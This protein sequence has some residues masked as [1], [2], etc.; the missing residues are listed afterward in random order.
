MPDK[1]G[2]VVGV[3]GMFRMLGGAIGISVITL[4]LNNSHSLQQG[5]F[6]VLFGTAIILVLSLPLIFIMP[7]DAG[8]LPID[9]VQD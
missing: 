6:I 3:R 5:F 4:A 7:K 8:E 9:K 1:V 2:T